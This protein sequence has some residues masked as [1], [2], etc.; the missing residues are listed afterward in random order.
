MGVFHIFEIVQMV[1]NR[2]SITFKTVIHN[3]ILLLVFSPVH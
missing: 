1:T 2:E 3:G